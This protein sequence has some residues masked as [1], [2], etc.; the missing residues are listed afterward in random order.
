MIEAR[1]ERH[2]AGNCRIAA[3]SVVVLT[4][5]ATAAAQTTGN[6]PPL[7]I[8]VTG[9]ASVTA[10]VVRVMELVGTGLA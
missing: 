4:L 5:T 9:E 1:R 6:V 7:S 8:R 10:T 2:M 3:V